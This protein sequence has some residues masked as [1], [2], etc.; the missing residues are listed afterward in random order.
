MYVHNFIVY[1]TELNM[2]VEPKPL[3]RTKIFFFLL[4]NISVAL[5]AEILWEPHEKIQD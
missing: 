4:Q 1:F 3:F 5:I 2:E